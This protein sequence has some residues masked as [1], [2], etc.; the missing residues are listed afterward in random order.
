MSF[1]LEKS[2]FKFMSYPSFAGAYTAL[3]TPFRNGSVDSNALMTLIEEQIKGGITGVVPVGTT[4]ESP[5]LSHEEHI[6]VVEMTV[7]AVNK[8]VKVIAGTGSN[9]TAEAVSLTQEAE[10]VGA[11]AALIVAPYYNKPSQAGLIAHFSAIAESTDLPII[12]Y[13]IP[14]RC[15]IEI[16]V[17]TVATL[18]KQHENI[19]AIKEAGGSIERVNQLRQKLPASFTILSGDDSLTLPFMSAG[20]V[21]VISVASN[22]VPE[23]VSQLVKAFLAGNISEAQAIHQ[24]WYPLFR[25]LFVE[26]NPVPIKTALARRGLMTEEVRLPLVALQPA[27]RT[28]LENTLAS[29]G[30]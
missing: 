4:G 12:L 19:V 7:Q 14:G 21:G 26:A 27:S 3:V 22:L 18:A 5:T 30:V 1:L 20:A 2:P 6:R 23:P 17:D 8:R 25:D 28:L 24:K 11:D 29:L 15:G 10:K 13:S 9:C 16:G